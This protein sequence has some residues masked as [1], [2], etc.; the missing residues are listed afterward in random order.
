MALI[1]SGTSVDR[2]QLA[3]PMVDLRKVAMAAAPSATGESVSA[4]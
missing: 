2:E 4:T 1:A 3:D